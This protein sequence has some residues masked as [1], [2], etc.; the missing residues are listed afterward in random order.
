VEKWHGDDDGDDEDF[1][2]SRKSA[3]KRKIPPNRKI[4]VKRLRRKVQQDEDEDDSDE[5]VEEWQGDDDSEDFAPS[6]KSKAKRKPPARRR[7]PKVQQDDGDDDSDDAMEERQGDD[8]DDDEDFAPSSK[9]KPPQPKRKTPAKRRRPGKTAI[10]DNE[11]GNDDDET[12][13]LD[14]DKNDTEI[15]AA[16]KRRAPARI[17]ARPQKRVASEEDSE[18][19]VAPSRSRTRGAARRDFYREQQSSEE[20]REEPRQRRF[21]AARASQKLQEMSQD[22]SEDEETEEPLKSPSKRKEQLSSDEEFLADDTSEPSVEEAVFD[23]ESE[24]EQ[25]T[26][27]NNSQ[28]AAD[29][30]DQDKPDAMDI[31]DDAIG[32]AEESSGDEQEETKP[33]SAFT[34]NHRREIR[35]SPRKGTFEASSSEDSEDFDEM[36]AV[37]STFKM[38]HCP[39]SEDAITAE[40]LPKMHVCYISPD[41]QS[42]QCFC[43]ETLRQ[44]ALKSARLPIRVDLD[45]STQITF[46]QPPHFRT[47]MSDDML[48][49]IASRFG[50][51]ALDL[52]GEF[53]NRK[54]QDWL[55]VGT[56]ADTHEDVFGTGTGIDY[57]EDFVGHVQSYM[58]NQMGSQDLYACPLC[59]SEM[60]RRVVRTDKPSND[61]DEDD[62][63]ENNEEVAAESV[64]DPMTVL[65]WLDNDKFEAASLFCFTKVAN[66]K[67]HLRGDHHVETKGIQGNDLYIRFRVRASDGLLQRYLKHS[68]R[69]GINFQ[70]DMRR[71]WNTGNNQSFVYLLDLMQKAQSYVQ[72]LQAA[73]VENDDREE[74]ESYISKARELF[75]SI[76]DKAQQEWERTSAPFLKSA[77][78]DLEDFLAKDGDV[79]EDETPHFLAHRQLV[80]EDNKLSNENDLV[81]KIQRKYADQADSDEEEFDMTGGV[82]SD[83][84]E[85]AAVYSDASDIN[86]HHGYYSEVEE[87]KDE[88]VE[89]I[90]NKKRKKT[91][92]ANGSHEKEEDATP[93]GKKLKIR[94]SSP[95]VA[96]VLGVSQA[97]P[98]EKRRTIVD[99][100]EEFDA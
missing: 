61:D 67:K 75:E 32:S 100:D 97:T 44:I 17:R 11:D 73:D 43:L 89:S 2:P 22:A 64:Y 49:Q 66:L 3:P 34:P 99:S 96:S 98:V 33:A 37:Q 93:I 63:E 85:G 78:D 58:D 62:E 21:S 77:N 68:Q 47:R 71:Y 69:G 86:G 54:P 35:P 10:Q 16:S 79:E 41:G 50:R 76:Q 15:I 42:R 51:E 59:Y 92:T 12:E 72:L 83:G 31:D 23:S 40:D 94:K 29:E 90:Q 74:A 46:L 57:E 7:L 26:T 70:G 84:E 80:N 45:G 18:E 65:G 60:H 25:I 9:R 13:E 56:N 24:D 53:F 36:S 14:V 4:P 28:E 52:H 1:T 48:D 55:D 20:E 27:R 19:V 91:S 5:D 8:D 39:S 95:S 38:P 30:S 82:N 6:R 88:W 87:E 81:H